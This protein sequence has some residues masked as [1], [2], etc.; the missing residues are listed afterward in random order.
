MYMPMNTWSDFDYTPY[1]RSTKPWVNAKRRL[2]WMR[3]K[4][5]DLEIEQS[6]IQ[7]PEFEYPRIENEEI[8]KPIQNTLENIHLTLNDAWNKKRSWQYFD[9]I[10][11]FMSRPRVWGHILVD[12]ELYEIRKL[13]MHTGWQVMVRKKD[14]SSQDTQEEIPMP[15]DFV[16]AHMIP[17]AQ[18]TEIITSQMLSFTGGWDDNGTYFKDQEWKKVPNMPTLIRETF[19]IFTSKD[20]FKINNIE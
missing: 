10:N 14:Y 18:A 19:K 9:Y 1:Q 2:K 15:Y 3:K 5:M 12:W 16:K 20:P 17:D 6:D 11:E 13:P 7:S 4:Q 8:I